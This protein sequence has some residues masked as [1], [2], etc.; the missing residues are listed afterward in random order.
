PTSVAPPPAESGTVKFL[1][2]QQWAVRMML[3]KAEPAT[4]ARQITATGRIVP[5][6]GHHAVVAPPVGGLLDGVLLPRVGQTVAQ[7]QTLA[8]VRQTPT[9]SESAQIAAGQAQVEIEGARL[10]AERRKLTEAARETEL[11]LNH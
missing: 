3:A 6:P 1:M 11:R 5:A 2:E 10:E 9:A 7:G 4:V 8:V